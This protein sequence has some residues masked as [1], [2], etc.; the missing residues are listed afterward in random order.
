VIRGNAPGGSVPNGDVFVRLIAV[1][2]T[3]RVNAEQLGDPFL[4]NSPIGNGAEVFGLSFTGIPVAPF[5]APVRVCLLGSG[6]FYYRDATA[7]PRITLRMNTINEGG[8]TCST[9]PNS[10]TIVLVTDGSQAA[11]TP[12]EG[13]T[14]L[15]DCTVTTRAIMNLRQSASPTAAIIRLIPFDVTLTAYAKQAGFYE[16][17]YL[18][19]RGWLSSSFLTLEF[20]C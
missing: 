10:G 16:V 3:L 20:G 14:V 7:S 1:N 12:L 17:D 4:I 11:T 19:T 9:L 8:Y 13:A 18:G 15:R 5:S 2:G 6:S